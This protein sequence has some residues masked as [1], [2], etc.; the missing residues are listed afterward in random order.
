M[1]SQ[2]MKEG[3]RK[4]KDKKENME[5]RDWFMCHREKMEE[6]RANKKWKTSTK[7]ENDDS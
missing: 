5:E 3:N 6:K 7:K 2:E 1:V 4:D